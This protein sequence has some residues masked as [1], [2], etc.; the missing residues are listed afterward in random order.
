MK[1]IITLT[2]GTGSFGTKSISRILSKFN[3]K[4]LRIF[5]RDE[6]KQWSLQEKYKNIKNIKFILG[7]VR[8]P[9]SLEVAFSDCDYVI[10]AAAT[11]IVPLAEE[12]PEEC[13]RTNVIGAT[14][15]INAAIK[16]NVKN[17]V[18][19]STDK[20]CNP[21]NLYGATKLCSDKL[22]IA[23]NFLKN[24]N[25]SK[26][27]IVRYGNVINSRGSVIP[28]FKSQIDQGYFSITDVKMTRF[29]ISLDQGI[30]LVFFVIR[31]QI[32]G[33]IYVPKIPSIKIVDLAK[34]LNPKNKIKIIG[35]R[36]GEKMHE[37]MISSEDSLYTFDYGK[38]YKIL[39][40][41]LQRKNIK[42]YV[43]NGKKVKLNFQYSSN[44]NKFLNN[45]EIKKI[46]KK[47]KNY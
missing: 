43:K 6:M 7:D 47:L 46:L 8:D 45:A 28:F 16:N 2:G 13:I 34:A 37:Q 33:E 1:K 18:A 10:H 36:P 41:L 21:I 39:P 42:K 3:P 14:N 19:L 40:S 23:A 20:A 31:D 22:F 12:N 17:V 5:S 30:D 4:E 26:F 38:Y 35:I 32:G 29:L 11:K 25:C 24:N 15:V 27:S 44:E 9:K